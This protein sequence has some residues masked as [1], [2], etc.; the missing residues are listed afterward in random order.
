MRTTAGADKPDDGY[1]VNKAKSKH[2]HLEEEDDD[3]DKAAAWAAVNKKSNVGIAP[4]VVV[5]SE[6][7]CCLSVKVLQ[8]FQRV[9]YS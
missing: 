6:L 8:S 4:S 3:D 7:P 9:G 5:I 2:F 1:G